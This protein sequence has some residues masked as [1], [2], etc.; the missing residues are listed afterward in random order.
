MWPSE[1]T[2]RLQVQIGSV[3]EYLRRGPGCIFLFHPGLG[4]LWDVIAQKLR[5]GVLAPGSELVLEVC[6]RLTT[7]ANSPIG[8]L[9]LLHC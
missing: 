2:G 7:P 5:G 1:V 3:E 9:R 4:P 6:L 8:H